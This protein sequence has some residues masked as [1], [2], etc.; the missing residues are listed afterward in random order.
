MNALTSSM[1]STRLGR[2]FSSEILM[3]FG[4]LYKHL[5]V[6]PLRLRRSVF[7]ICWL[8]KLISST[9]QF[10]LT[11]ERSRNVLCR[12][13]FLNARLQSAVPLFSKGHVT[14]GQVSDNWKR[15]RRGADVQ[16]S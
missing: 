4:R 3:Y 1:I 2:T 7:V 14:E 10:R 6:G 8:L 11:V 13:P 16:K 12:V 9:S 5:S 15:E